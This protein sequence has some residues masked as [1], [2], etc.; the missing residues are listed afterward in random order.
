M[1]A[2]TAALSDGVENGGDGATSGE[3]GSLAIAFERSAARF[4]DRIAVASPSWTATYAELDAAA[5]RLA[6][7]IIAHGGAPGDRIAV[8]M[9]HDTP[10]IAALFAVFKAGRIVVALNPADPPARLR[11]RLIDAGAQLVVSDRATAEIAGSVVESRQRLVLFEDIDV[12]NELPP[13]VLDLLLS[14]AI[15]W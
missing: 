11:E 9:R 6:R 10:Q 14:W 5:N 13:L 7:A 1:S 8:L 4:G 2:P 12:L 3:D 15:Q